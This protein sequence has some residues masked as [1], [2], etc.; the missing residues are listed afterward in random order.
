MTSLARALEDVFESSQKSLGFYSYE[1]PSPRLS[2]AEFGVLVSQRRDQLKALGAGPGIVVGVLGPTCLELAIT[3]AA[4]WTS[5]A[6]LT[7]LPTPTRMGQLELYLTQTVSKLNTCEASLLVGEPNMVEGFVDFLEIPAL[8]WDQLPKAQLTSPL[9]R[10]DLG[11]HQPALIQFSSGTTSDPRPI[12]L[13]AEALL[14][15]SKAVLDCFPGGAHEHSCVSWLPLYHDMGLIGCFLMPILAPGN[16]TLL[17]AEVFAARPFVWLQAISQER[18]TTSSAPNFA[19]AHCADRITSEQVN[20]LD[21]SCWQISMVGAEA[22][23]PQTLRRFS[24]RFAPSGFCEDAFSPVYGLAEATL[25]VTFSPLGGG[26]RSLLLDADEMAASG[27]VA[28]GERESVSLGK[29]LGVTQ[30]EV[31]DDR[32]QVLGEDQ[33]GQVWVKGPSLLSGVLGV[34][35]EPLREGWLDTGDL[36]FLHQGD[37]HIYGRRRDIL[38][39]DGRNHDPDLLEAAP[40]DLPRLRRSC[41][42]TYEAPGGQRDELVLI[43]EVSKRWKGDPEEYAD[44][45]KVAC[46]KH[47]GL[48]PHRVHLT[49]AGELPVTSSGKLRRGEAARMYASGELTLVT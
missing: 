2:Y 15:N 48:V 38:L 4:V 22:V 27:K 3:C 36:G 42:F 12:M 43:C 11:G 47:A 28:P 40:Q 9:N 19:F 39:L 31:R 46:R 24:E 23:R 21:L 17:P 20:S 44:Q 26:L 37:L 34:T 35:E 1:G 8:A 25:A 45:V 7:V 41:A 14:A 10:P 30:V 6:T 32:G 16:L 18:A 13:S 33:L 5:G 29:P 49:R